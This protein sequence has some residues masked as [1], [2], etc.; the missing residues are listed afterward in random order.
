MEST[1]MDPLG[2]ELQDFDLGRLGVSGTEPQRSEAT[3]EGHLLCYGVSYIT[4]GASQTMRARR[5][6]DF[7]ATGPTLPQINMESS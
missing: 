2:T 1:Y 5:Y 6:Q 4:Y 3:S 7:R